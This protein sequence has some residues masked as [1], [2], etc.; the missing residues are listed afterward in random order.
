MPGIDELILDLTER[1]CQRFQ[2]LTG[3]TN[4]WLAVQ[5]T[6]L[7]IIIYFFSAAIYFPAVQSA[8]ARG[9]RSRSSAAASCTC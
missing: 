2:V 9:S 7:S 6:N 3:R 4:V 1:L 8:R 5:L